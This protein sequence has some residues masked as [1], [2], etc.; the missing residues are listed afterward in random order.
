[1]IYI[2]KETPKNNSKITNYP[3]QGQVKREYKTSR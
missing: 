1:M 2:I 3:R